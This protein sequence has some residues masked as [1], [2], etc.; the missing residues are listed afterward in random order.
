[1]LKP[2]AAD[3]FRDNMEFL[4][5]RPP[6]QPPVPEAPR[7]LPP[8]LLVEGIFTDRQLKQTQAATQVAHR[9]STRT[10]IQETI[11]EPESPDRPEARG[12]RRK[13]QE[14]T[15]HRGQRDTKTART[16]DHN[17]SQRAQVRGQAPAP[18]SQRPISRPTSWP[19]SGPPAPPCLKY[20]GPSRPRTPSQRS[21]S[22]PLPSRWSVGSS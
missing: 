7:P 21:W 3:L 13:E 18:A 5:L 11:R 19:P 10:G 6:P 20:S 17:Q 9:Q 8:R 16:A 15:E 12:R 4:E 14:Q 22:S 2:G 1:M